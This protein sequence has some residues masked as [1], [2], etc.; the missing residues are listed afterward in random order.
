MQDSDWL[1]QERQFT[2]SHGKDSTLSPIDSWSSVRFT[3]CLKCKKTSK[4]ITLK[5]NR[6]F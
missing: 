3:E 2:L 1:L 4:I 6:L 5:F